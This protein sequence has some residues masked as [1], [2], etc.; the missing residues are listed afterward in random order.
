MKNSVDIFTQPLIWFF[1]LLLEILGQ[2]SQIRFFKLNIFFHMN[3][4]ENITNKSYTLYLIFLHKHH[5]H[6]NQVNFGLKNWRRKLKLLN[7]WQLWPSYLAKYQKNPLRKFNWFD[8]KICQTSLSSLWNSK[9]F[10]MLREIS[11]LSLIH[12]ACHLLRIT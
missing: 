10:L 12:H 7:F 4:I 5:F 3:K 6:N 9:T 1:V 8:F 2:R 11:F